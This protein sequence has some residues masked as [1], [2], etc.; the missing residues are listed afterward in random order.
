VAHAAQ[1]AK[2]TAQA[3]IE[4][5][6]RSRLHGQSEAVCSQCALTVAVSPATPSNSAAGKAA[7]RARS[8]PRERPHAAM[9]PS[10]TSPAAAG[11][12]PPSAPSFWEP[13]QAPATA[14][15]AAAAAPHSSGGR[16]VW[17]KSGVRWWPARELPSTVQVGLE[18]AERGKVWV[19][20]LGGNRPCAQVSVG[21]ISSFLENFNGRYSPK[22]EAEEY[23]RGIREALDTL[24]EA[25]VEDA[26]LSLARHDTATELRSRSPTTTTA[27]TATDVRYTSPQPRGDA[28]RAGRETPEPPTGAGWAKPSPGS[29]AEETN[30]LFRPEVPPSQ[31]QR[32]SQRG[33]QRE[34][35]PAPFPSYERP[36]T[37]AM[38]RKESAAAGCSS[39]R[40]LP[41][42]AAERKAPRLSMRS[43]SPLPCRSGENGPLPCRSGE[44][45][46]LPCR[47]GENGPLP[48]PPSG[49][50][51]SKRMGSHRGKFGT[52]YYNSSAH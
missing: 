50:L 8:A 35:S 18:P 11:K 32:S 3:Q 40:E 16:V 44:N 25:S 6:R 27:A 51:P 36:M 48:P 28:R 23:K 15:V 9:R 21:D 4:R 13:G 46:P 24:Q 39:T 34:T 33:A 17:A 22:L 41:R 30:P 49:Q 12:G 20:W 26:E 10:G 31:R 29:R 47:S 43:R 37:Q 38:R 1:H 52:E 7:A 45:G 2:A 5:M 42:R 14:A 19:A